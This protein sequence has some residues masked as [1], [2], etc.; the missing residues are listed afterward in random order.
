MSGIR[1]YRDEKLPFLEIKF[2][3][4][5]VHSTKMHSHEELS[6]GIIESGSSSVV[7]EGT[8]F[9]V[10]RGNII[11]I[12]PQAVHMCSPEAASQ[13]TFKML[14]LKNSWV[15]KSFNMDITKI[16]TFSRTLDSGEFERITGLTALLQENLSGFEKETCLINEL[17]YFLPMESHSLPR[18]INKTTETKAIQR[19]RNHLDA[20]FLSGASLD[21][22]ALVSGLSKYHIIRLFNKHCKLSPHAYQTMLRINYAKARL[23]DRCPIAQVA[24]DTGFFDQSHF[25]KTFKQYSGTTP[26]EYIAGQA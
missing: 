15:E 21:D 5:G 14:F 17:A 7:C 24:V 16:S 11:Y 26:L 3:D 19:M 25:T 2:C 12:P 20:N 22:L 8:N 10:S 9:N 23:R 18:K 6:I 1:Y 4:S 13:W